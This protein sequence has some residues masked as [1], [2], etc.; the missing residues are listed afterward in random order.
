MRLYR[1]GKPVNFGSS[2]FPTISEAIEFKK[3]NEENIISIMWLRNRQLFDQYFEQNGI[4]YR[5]KSPQ[6]YALANPVIESMTIEKFEE[7]LQ[8]PII[9][10]IYWD[11]EY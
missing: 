11:G 9:S 8:H 7:R 4:G 3:P 6:D 10:K 1:K 2:W 5:A